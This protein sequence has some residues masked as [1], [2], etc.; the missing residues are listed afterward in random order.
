[1]LTCCDVILGMSRGSCSVAKDCEGLYYVSNEDLFVFSNNRREL[2]LLRNISCM[3]MAG[4]W[5]YDS[6]MI[7]Q[8]LDEFYSMF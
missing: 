3:D 4:D 7:D 2:S 6:V 5:K 1:M 8:H